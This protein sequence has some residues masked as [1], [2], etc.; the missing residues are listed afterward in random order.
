MKQKKFTYYLHASLV[1]LIALVGI[2]SFIMYYDIIG[3]SLQSVLRL[4]T[5]PSY[6]G[7]RVTAVFYDPLGDDHGYGGL[8][9]PQSKDFAPG[10][11]DLVRYTVHEP[12]YNA[13]WTPLPDYWQLDLAF[14]S[15]T[16]N[17]GNTRNIRI[18][19]DADGDGKGSTETKT[20]FAEGVEFDSSFLWDW[21]LSIQG[22]AGTIQSSDGKIIEPLKVSVSKSRKEVIVRVPLKNRVLQA[23]YTVPTTRH[24]V[25][26]GAW[27][28]WGRDGFIDM[29]E[30]AEAGK[31]GGAVS[32]LTPKLYDILVPEDKKQE[33]ILSAWNDDELTMPVLFPV[34]VVMHPPVGKDNSAFF[35]VSSSR[36]QE[37]EEKI[38]AEGEK[39]R[40]VALDSYAKAPA[41]TEEQAIAAF[42]AGKNTEAEMLFDRLL[43]VKSDS[44]IDLAF[45]G[46]L[47]AMRGGEAPPLAAVDI[48]A[49]AYTYLDRAVQLAS[50]PGEKITSYMNRANVSKAVPD[51][52]FGKALQGAEDFLAAAAEFKKLGSSDDMVSAYCNAALCFELGGNKGE[53]E[54]WFREAARIADAKEGK[55]SSSVALELLKRGIIK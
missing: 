35:T 52:V 42:Y 36:M 29:A 26:V 6:I 47:S 14:A 15:S 5:D 44:S 3:R 49:E 48:I 13:Q 24:Y 34:E 4:E 54:T 20:D 16:G 46:S 19:I 12:V 25:C 31:G 7:G 28:P 32:S 40:S 37:L 51:L 1:L 55:A 38:K 9:Y 11:L 23:L 22:T 41:G 10:S 53:A 39:A 30:K 17:A 45:K 43:A 50:N 27:S 18:Y 2:S 8:L 21:V 33:Q